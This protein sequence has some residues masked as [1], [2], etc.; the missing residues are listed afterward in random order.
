MPCSAPASTCD[1]PTA[2]RARPRHRRT[3][4]RLAWGVELGVIAFAL[5]QAWLIVNT[6]ELRDRVTNIAHRGSSLIAP[7]NTLAAVGRAVEDGAD[8]VEIDVRLTADGQAVLF[9][10]RSL[11]ATPATCAI[12]IARNWVPSTWAAGSEMPTSASGFPAST[13][14]WRWCA[15]AA[16]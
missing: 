5:F 2:S 4:G 15:A 3:R 9:H 6:F 12:W 10:V 11:E 16:A 14:R 7:E 1:W 13:R 8:Y